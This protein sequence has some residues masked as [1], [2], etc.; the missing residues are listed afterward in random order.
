ML[1][2]YPKSIKIGTLINVIIGIFGIL[3]GVLE[4]EEWP[5]LIFGPFIAITLILFF[6]S[7][8]TNNNPTIKPIYHGLFWGL[9]LP[10]ILFIL[11]L[12]GY[13][14]ADRLDTGGG[15]TDMAGLGGFMLMIVLGVVSVM[16]FVIALLIGLIISYRTSRNKIVLGLAIIT[17]LL[18]I[19][20]II[21][22]IL[23]LEGSILNL[24][25]FF[26]GLF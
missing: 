14:I 24:N 19:T 8:F 12:L 6:I 11:I 15:S 21:L 13:W 25:Y 23:T 3:F 20:A 26:A 17:A 7:K 1:E 18:L 5:F 22:I 10:A 16:V 9:S 4:V 2:K